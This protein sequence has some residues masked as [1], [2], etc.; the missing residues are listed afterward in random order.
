MRKLPDYELF[1]RNTQA[2][3]YG[4][5]QRAVQRMLDYDYLCR[6]E[7]PSV[8]AVIDPT[9]EGYMKVF[10]G[11]KEILI[12]IYRSIQDAVE[13]HPNADVM[14]NFASYRSAYPT[15]KEALETDTIRTVAVIA[16]GV[17]ERYERERADQ[18]KK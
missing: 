10:F 6:R 14:V 5:Q 13:R 7:R 11:T 9:R 4:N 8:A 18:A 16:E 3:V 15:T 17:P 1:D 2:I 12:P